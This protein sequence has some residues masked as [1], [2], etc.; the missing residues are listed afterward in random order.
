MEKII[1]SDTI[2]IGDFVEGIDTLRLKQKGIVIGFFNSP[3]YGYGVY[4]A[5][6]NEK[7]KNEKHKKKI[8]GCDLV[9]EENLLILPQYTQIAGLAHV[10]LKTCKILNK[11]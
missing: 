5:S 1:I 4:I 10:T 2:K 8:L 3:S 6:E 9:N 11:T 7:H